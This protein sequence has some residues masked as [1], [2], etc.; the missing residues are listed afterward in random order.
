MAS[1]RSIAQF[2]RLRY[3]IVNRAG[4]ATETLVMS[5][6]LGGLATFWETQIDT[7]AEHFRVITYDHRGT[8]ENAGPLPKRYTISDMVSDVV[9]ILDDAG[10]DHCHFIGH[11]LGGLV[12]LE[13]ALK[14]SERL[15][16]LVVVNGWAKAN[17]HTRRCF[18]ARVALLKA[19][20]HEAYI[21]AQPI[22]LYP[23]AYSSRHHQ[24]IEKGNRQAIA[25]FQGAENLLMRVD[26]L[27]S[28]DVSQTLSGIRTPTLMMAARDDILVPYTCSELL[29]SGIPNSELSMVAEGGHACSVTEPLRFN[30][31]LLCFLRSFEQASR[32]G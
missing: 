22:F 2:N 9:E 1:R 21:E 5:A 28:F 20:G 10:I 17:L 16:S 25:H 7:L 19:A 11:A 27:L 6:G 31:I 32:H 23:A 18:A 24:R 3:R 12:G 8:G 26:A 29:A 15:S 30:R 14:A 13:L 4:S